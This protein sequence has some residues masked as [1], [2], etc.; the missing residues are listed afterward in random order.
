MCIDFYENDKVAVGTG[1]HQVKILQENFLII[2]KLIM[3]LGS[4]I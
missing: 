3:D 2:L 1:H 4:S